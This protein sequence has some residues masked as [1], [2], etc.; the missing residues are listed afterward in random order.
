MA[1]GLNFSALAADPSFVAPQA[2]TT[3]KTAE[4]YV[5]ISFPMELADGTIVHIPLPLGIPVDFIEVN[6]K[7]YVGNYSGEDRKQMQSAVKLLVD[8]LRAAGESLEAGASMDLGEVHASLQRRSNTEVVA[9]APTLGTFAFATAARA[10][11]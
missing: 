1:Q 7:T 11:K 4:V 8:Q 6:S 10:G 9:S 5:N 2:A 3:K